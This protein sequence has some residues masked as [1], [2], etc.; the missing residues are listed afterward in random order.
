M[1]KTAPFTS[2]ILFNNTPLTLM[3]YLGVL[4][5]ELPDWLTVARAGK[6]PGSPVLHAASP[7]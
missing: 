4:R 1:D 7:L 2:T 6:C 5:N 3:L